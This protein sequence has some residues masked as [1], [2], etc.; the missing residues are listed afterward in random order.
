MTD[1]QFLTWIQEYLTAI[2]ASKY[3][4]N[5]ERMAYELGLAQ[6]LL[7]TLAANDSHNATH[8]SKTFKKIVTSSTKR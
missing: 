3:R 5:Y 7:A 8:I 1:E 2:S 4:S 6:Q